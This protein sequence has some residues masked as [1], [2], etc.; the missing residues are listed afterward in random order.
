MP[1][2]E[3]MANQLES[4]LK[5]FSGQQVSTQ[6]QGFLKALSDEL[7]QQMPAEE[8]ESL[9]YVLG[10]RMANDIRPDVGGTLEQMQAAIN[11][12]WAAMNWGWVNVKDVQTSLEIVHCCAPFRAAFGDDALQWAGALLEGIYS[13]WFE[14]IGAGDDLVLRQIDMEAGSVDSYRYRLAHRSLFG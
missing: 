14:E 3:Y 2:S 8:I 10:R 7:R 1:P 12:V 5:Y 9:M 4:S 6:W 13:L 11:D